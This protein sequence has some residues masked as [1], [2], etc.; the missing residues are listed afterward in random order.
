MRS[1]VFTEDAIAADNQSGLRGLFKSD[2]LRQATDDSV[3]MQYAACSHLGVT[4]NDRM[5]FKNNA[6][7]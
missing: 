7:A 2:N 6:R 1:C 4:S 5:R 3:W